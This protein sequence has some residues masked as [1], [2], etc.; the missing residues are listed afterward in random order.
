MF[1]FLIAFSFLMI[2]IGFNV[3]K[4]HDSEMSIL[5]R[6]FTNYLQLISA[7]LS[8]NLRYPSIISDIQWLDTKNYLKGTKTFMEEKNGR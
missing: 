1:I 4:T 7:T 8:F 6:I 3:R 2:L 5:M